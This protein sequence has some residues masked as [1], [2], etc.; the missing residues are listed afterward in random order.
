MRL[1]DF[2]YPLPAGRIAQYP[3]RERDRS[4]LLV[5]HR[6]TGEMEH[7]MFRDIT[8]Y[9]HRGDVLVINDTRVMP[10]RLCGAKPSGGRAEITLLRELGKNTWEALVKGLHEGS[11]I[12]P[13]GI[14]AGV[15]RI[16]AETARVTFDLGSVRYERGD[17]DIR[18]FLGGIGVMPLP[19]YIKRPAVRADAEQYQTVYAK[20]D[21]AVAAPTA[22]LHFTE[23]LLHT[24]RERGVEIKTITLHVGRGTFRPVTAEHIREHK[25]DEE[26]FEIPASTSDAVNSAKTE[27]RRVIA[28]GT[29]VTRALESCAAGTG[30]RPGRGSASIFIYPGYRF[31]IVDA[32]ITNFHLPRSTPMMLAA[33]FSGLDLL[34][35]AY[36]ESV[37]RGY[38]FF[39]YGD[40]MLII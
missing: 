15:R 35:K 9:L 40:A 39:S 20:K 19:P 17:A 37:K 28:T 12:L 23:E 7:R 1:S 11:V 36:S 2:D 27:G 31:R 25:M 4:A 26:E 13:H 16:N 3:L 24:L 34:K 30:V 29:T 10:V 18:D 33:A 5:L 22:G 21:G 32:L 6:H 8:G 14:T 38:R